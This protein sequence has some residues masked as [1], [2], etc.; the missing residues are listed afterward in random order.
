MGLAEPHDAAWVSVIDMMALGRL[1]TTDLTGPA[2]NVA[3][4]DLS[5]AECPSAS[6]LCGPVGA[7]WVTTFAW[8]GHLSFI[9]QILYD[10]MGLDFQLLAHGVLSTVE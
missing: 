2:L 8:S 10:V 7:V 4:S 6:L 9:L 5:L 3:T 1:S